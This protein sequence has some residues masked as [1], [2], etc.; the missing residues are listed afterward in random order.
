MIPAGIGNLNKA[1]VRIR[2][3]VDHQPADRHSSVYWWLDFLALL[4]VVF[5]ESLQ[6]K[7]EL[8][9]DVI[10]TSDCELDAKCIRES[11]GT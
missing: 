3:G 4:R 11:R 5:N 6:K 1:K 2:K 9:Y 8:K 7:N 10:F